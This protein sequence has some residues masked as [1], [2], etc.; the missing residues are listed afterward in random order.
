MIDDGANDWVEPTWY[1]ATTAPR[2]LDVVWCRFP[3][4][5]IAAHK[6]RPC[7]VK[8]VLEDVGD[9]AGQIW[10]EVS[11]GTT[12]IEKARRGVGS[13]VISN[14]AEL[15]AIG[16]Y[17]NT[18]FELLNTQKL[19]WALEHFPNAPGRSTPIVGHFTNHQ[20][21]RLAEWSKK[22]KIVIDALKAGE[23]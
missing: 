10:L 1:P 13:F 20:R 6:D 19:P 17:K 12:K 2:L 11:Y 22:T 14:Y 9:R 3:F 4:D 21:V 8:D 15:Q 5:D 23:S 18:R 16:L 7:L